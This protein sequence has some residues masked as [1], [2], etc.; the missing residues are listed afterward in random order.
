M[1]D[2]LLVLIELFCQLSRLRRYEQILVEIVVYDRGCVT[3]NANFREKGGRVVHQRL[4]VV[5]VILCL[6]ALIQY[7]RVTHRQTHNDDYYPRVACAARVK[8]MVT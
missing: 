4:G 6:A 3:L 1:V 7:P 8:N 5:C 2:F